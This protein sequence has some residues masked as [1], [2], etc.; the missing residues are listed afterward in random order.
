MDE[1]DSSLVARTLGGEPRAFEELAHR[2]RPGLIRCVKLMIGDAD[3]AESL[4]Q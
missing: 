2:H 3:E 4:A 1:P